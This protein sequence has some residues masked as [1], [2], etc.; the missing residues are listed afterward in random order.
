MG[1]NIDIQEMYDT[2]EKQSYVG[3]LSSAMALFIV[4]L[5]LISCIGAGTL[6]QYACA[7]GM[8][9]VPF[10]VVVSVIAVSLAKEANTCIVLEESHK[11]S[12]TDIKK[13][14]RYALVVD[15]IVAV[16]YVVNGLLVCGKLFF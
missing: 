2:W 11:K 6:N 3:T 7:L 8:V 16:L 9:V 1:D 12:I 15:I 10:L 4:F 14:T 5:S 13:N